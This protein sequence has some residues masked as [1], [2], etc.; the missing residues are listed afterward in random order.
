MW[1]WWF[2]PKSGYSVIKIPLG[3]ILIILFVVSLISGIIF[4]VNAFWLHPIYTGALLFVFSPFLVPVFFS[5]VIFS[6]GLFYLPYYVFNEE[7]EEKR[8]WK[9]LLKYIGILFVTCVI[10][11]IIRTLTFGFA[12]PF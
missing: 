10:L 6:G 5:D 7:R 4:L 3:I 1:K 8:N 11:N 2:H 9:T 12:Y